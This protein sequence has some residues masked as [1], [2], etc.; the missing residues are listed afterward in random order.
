[1]VDQ[2]RILIVDDDPGM[3]ETLADILELEGFHVVTVQD[4]RRAL[5]VIQDQA[6]QLIVMDL[7]MPGISGLDAFRE[8]I[9]IDPDARIVF[10]TAYYQEEAVRAAISEGAVGVLKKPL[11]IPKLL[12]VIHGLL[13]G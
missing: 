7:K 4:G 12:D 6:F 5:D 2:P 11:D 9:Q 13:P 1:M 3:V 10:M 8:I